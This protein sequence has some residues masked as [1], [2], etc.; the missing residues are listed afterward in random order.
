[1]CILNSTMFIDLYN[2]Y[3]K[4]K[5]Y[6]IFVKYKKYKFGIFFNV[7]NLV[8]LTPTYNAVTYNNLKIVKWFINYSVDLKLKRVDCIYYI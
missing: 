6:E 1:M 2:Y 7:Y 3:N 5:N 4:L 8:Y